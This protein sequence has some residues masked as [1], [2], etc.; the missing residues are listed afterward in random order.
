MTLENDKTPDE[1]TYWEG[2]IEE[3]KKAFGGCLKC[4]GKGYSTQIVEGDR[5]SIDTCSCDRG[6]QVDDLLHN[7]HMETIRV[8]LEEAEKVLPEFIEEHWP[9][10][11]KSKERGAATVHIALFLAEMRK[12]AGL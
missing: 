5:H 12:A 9:K 2:K 8:L 3:T 11:A 1:T 4:Y 6:K 10:K 7:T